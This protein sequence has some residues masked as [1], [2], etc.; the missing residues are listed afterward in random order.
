MCPDAISVAV[1]STVAFSLIQ[2]LLLTCA[3]IFTEVH[4]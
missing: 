1:M 2:I 4:N 3:D